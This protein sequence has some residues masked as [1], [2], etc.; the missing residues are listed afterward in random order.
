MQNELQINKFQ[1]KGLHPFFT[2]AQNQS[3]EASA[4]TARKPSRL[5]WEFHLS[6]ALGCFHD[7]GS[8]KLNSDDDSMAPVN[9]NKTL[10]VNLP[11][12][13]KSRFSHRSFCN[14]I[15]WN[16]LTDRQLSII[17]RYYPCAN[18]ATQ[19]TKLK[20]GAGGWGLDPLFKGE[21]SGL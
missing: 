6:L 8:L 4:A 21:K 7:Q 16:K 3:A 18:G 12:V 17:W 5:L 10:S 15:H 2:P 1:E 13:G 14:W 9:P 19:K 11:K 20:E